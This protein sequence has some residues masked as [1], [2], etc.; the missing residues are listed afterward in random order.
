MLLW[1]CYVHQTSF[2]TLFSH[3]QAL[4]FFSVLFSPVFPG[5]LGGIDTVSGSS[6][7]SQHFDQLGVFTLTTAHGERSFS[8][9][10]LGVKFTLWR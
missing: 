10:F 1:L 7:Y 5:S 4:T 6:T 8:E 2:Q 3:P 9:V